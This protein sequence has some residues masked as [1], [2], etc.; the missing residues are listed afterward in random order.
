MAAKADA[1]NSQSDVHKISLFLTSHQD[2]F[3]RER[4]I[5]KQEVFPDL[6]AWCEDKNIY[7]TVKDIR[8]GAY[9]NR[10]ELE[11][12]ISTT[13]TLYYE[14]QLPFFINLTGDSIGRV[15]CRDQASDHVVNE[16]QQLLNISPEEAYLIYS[17]HREDNPNVLMLLRQ[18]EF[19]SY[20][21][22]KEREHFVPHR[23]L[24]RDSVC[25]GLNL[26]HSTFKG[27]RIIKYSY[28]AADWNTEKHRVEVDIQEQQA[29]V[30]QILQVLKQLICSHLKLSP[31]SDDLDPYELM[32][33]AHHAFLSTRS[34]KVRGRE[35]LIEQ[36][37]VYCLG[38]ACEVPL[39]L[40]GGAGS[41]KSSIMAQTAHTLRDTV[42]KGLHPGN[43]GC[44]VFYH[45]V[46]A[47]P[48]STSLA[49]M[50]HRMLKELNICFQILNELLETHGY[51]KRLSQAQVQLLLSNKA[52]ENPL[53]LWVACE[54]IC[55]IDSPELLSEKIISLPDGLLDLLED[56]LSRLESEAGGALFVAAV[57]L[58]EVS[59]SGLLE[60]EMRQMLGKSSELVP[61]S[62]FD[63]KEEKESL[64]K[65]D[66]SEKS[67]KSL[68]S[69][70]WSMLYKGLQ[71]FLRPYGNRKDGRLD[72]YHRALSKAVRRKY[73]KDGHENVD[74]EESQE[75][76]HFWHQ[77]LADFF[78]NSSNL[79][80]KTEEYMYHLSKI[81]DCSRLASCLTDWNI[82]SRLYHAEYSSQLLGYW[83]DAGGTSLMIAS[84]KEALAD[85]ESSLPCDEHFLA[86]CYEQVARIFLQ[87][88]SY[89]E[90]L[91]L[92]TMA[93]KWE[94]KE[95]GN[96]PD[97]MV[98]LYGLMS[99]I[100]DEKLKL[101]DFV[102]PTQLPDLRK[103]ISY[104]RKSISLREK[105]TD[106]SSVLSPERLAY[107]KFK[108]G[109]SLMKLAFSLESWEACG[110]D[111]DMTGD[112]ALAE[113]NKHIDAAM[114]IFEQL[115]D[116]GHYAEA[117]MTKG[118]LAKRGSDQ[119]LEHYN[120]AMDIC[121]QV[122]GDHSLLT[123]R[124]YINIG[125]VYEDNQNFVL[126]FDYFKK[127]ARVSEMVLGPEHPKT[128]RAKGVLKEPR[129]SLV[130]QRLRQREEQQEEA[131]ND[132]GNRV[133]SID[134]INEEVERLASREVS[135]VTYGNN[136]DEFNERNEAEGEALQVS[137]DLQQAIN[138]LLQ[139]AL[140]E[141]EIRE[142][143]ADDLLGR[144]EE[145]IQQAG[146]LRV[147]LNVMNNEENIDSNILSENLINL[148]LNNSNEEANEEP[149]DEHQ[150][151]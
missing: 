90:S 8:W 58:L 129:Y 14:S 150:S 39:L 99:E 106:N 71:P 76:Y 9:H 29:L 55:R 119:Q 72:F 57:C 116:S 108:L 147:T 38:D 92:T 60:D 62:P 12:I 134:A 33:R 73:L 93:I 151:E 121:R 101:N 80:R 74:R 13:Q 7:L 81:S 96:R 123:S 3:G 118:V 110:G 54:E 97:R 104:G 109:M 91:D 146:N 40:L 94:E 36:I 78:E 23:E 89:T 70:S 34:A 41:G 84:Y 53:W 136:E 135:M 37:K 35:D 4:Q 46:G 95:L 18:D 64:E 86:L 82:M 31:A 11:D 105:F 138:D 59:S 52:S 128:L 140:G 125:I 124:L 68:S 113:G 130:S 49:C 16:Y 88:G 25:T 132:G 141:L 26:L 127:W 115:Q 69:E 75:L 44:T 43:E 10:H 83:R 148:A 45:F 87:A 24:S 19:F 100:Y 77:K 65:E 22:E 48:G 67:K 133:V 112:E 51:D 17:S 120:K 139:R 32:R 21:G 144:V 122:Y 142:H 149:E 42:L 79:D 30:S 85:M 28:E 145:Q 6:Q 98:E 126:A 61:P 111:M 107:H 56:V 15:P 63:E 50:L 103:T 66:S 131:G 102:S 2:D 117:L 137:E 5:L 27:D 47:L 114:V 1:V 20:L 143:Q